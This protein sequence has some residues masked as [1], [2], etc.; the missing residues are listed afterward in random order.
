M[1]CRFYLLKTV[2]TTHLYN[3]ARHH[4]FLIRSKSESQNYMFLAF[5]FVFFPNVA[6]TRCFATQKFDSGLKM[7][8]I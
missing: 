7:S 4:H 8:A 3:G 2:E 5:G 6:S 1:D